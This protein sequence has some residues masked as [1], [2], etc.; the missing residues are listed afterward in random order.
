MGPIHFIRPPYVSPRC[1]RSRGSFCGCPDGR[2]AQYRRRQIWVEAG[3]HA[4]A[5]IRLSGASGNI[6]RND[7][8]EAPP[9]DVYLG[10]TSVP[11]T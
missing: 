3:D 10:N 6:W 2:C 8:V 9:Q 5:L 4:P 7:D 11:I 1:A